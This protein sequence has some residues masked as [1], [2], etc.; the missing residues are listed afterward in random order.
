MVPLVQ[1]P[2]TSDAHGPPDDVLSVEHNSH[3]FPSAHGYVGS[4]PAVVEGEIATHI[5]PE[6]AGNSTIIPESYTILESHSELESEAQISL[7]EQGP[8]HLPFGSGSPVGPLEVLCQYC[9]ELAGHSTVSL[10]I[11][12]ALL[13]HTAPPLP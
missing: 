6:P 3:S 4:T 9:P 7:Q 12:D 2:T 11:Y 5:S 8:I 13:F 1:T 10:T